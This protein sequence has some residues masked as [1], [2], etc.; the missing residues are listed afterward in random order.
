MLYADPPYLVK[1]K[2]LYMSAQSWE[3]HEKL[4]TALLQ[5][6]HPWILTYELDERIRTFTHQID[7][8]NTTFPTRPNHKKSD[9][10]LWYLVVA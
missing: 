3:D 7:A 1:G 5:I 9:V 10:N 4:A 6:R 8:L 2:D